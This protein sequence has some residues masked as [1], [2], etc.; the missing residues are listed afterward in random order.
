[1]QEIVKGFGAEMKRKISQN[2]EQ[3]WLN[4]KIRGSFSPPLEAKI[5]NKYERKTDFA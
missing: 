5:C 2:F 4:L 3:Y 1:M